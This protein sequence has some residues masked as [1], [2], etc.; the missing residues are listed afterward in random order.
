MQKKPLGGRREL[1]TL[2][3]VHTN[4]QSMIAD[5]TLGLY[6]MRES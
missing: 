1:C 2:L 6:F 4:N 3:S 5:T